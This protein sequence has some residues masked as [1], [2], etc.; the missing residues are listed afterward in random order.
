LDTSFASSL[1]SSTKPPTPKIE[2]LPEDLIDLIKRY[3]HLEYK[4]NIDKERIQLVIA[5]HDR[6]KT[7][8]GHI[9]ND[10]INKDLAM[11]DMSYFKFSIY[12]L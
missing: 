6:Y 1:R 12:D 11:Y 4:Y 9:N 10:L 7:T 2:A 3:R 5:C 8:T